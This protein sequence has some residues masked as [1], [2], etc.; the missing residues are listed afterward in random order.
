[1]V[2]RSSVVQD[3]ERMK[4][5]KEEFNLMNSVT[6]WVGFRERVKLCLNSDAIDK[7]CLCVPSSLG[8]PVGY[9]GT[10]PE[11]VR[12]DLS[13]LQNLKWGALRT[14]AVKLDTGEFPRLCHMKHDF[15]L[16]VKSLCKGV[17]CPQR[18]I[19]PPRLTT[20]HG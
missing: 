3:T 11:R 8:L 10:N 19:N 17:M 15:C 2:L 6:K 1:M 16:P 20:L 18:Y 9:F 4:R 12:I 5:M 7:V 14:Q 13:E